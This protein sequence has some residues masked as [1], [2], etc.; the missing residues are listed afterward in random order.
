MLRRVLET[1]KKGLLVLPYIALVQE[2]TKWLRAI[3][4]GIEKNIEESIPGAFNSLRR[5]DRSIRVVP[6]FGGSK[7]RAT[8]ED[9]DI[10]IATIEKVRRSI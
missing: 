3:V 10:A 8:L 9:A 4:S 2:K 6:F 5:H 7:Q 1:G